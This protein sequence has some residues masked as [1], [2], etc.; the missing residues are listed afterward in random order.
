MSRQDRTVPALTRGATAVAVAFLVSGV[1]H[2]RRPQV[3][4]GA[5]PHG[6]PAPRALVILSGVAELACAAGLAWPASRRPAGLA[7]AGLLLA[8]FP[9]NV[10][11]LADARRAAR[12]RPTA[13]RRVREAVLW[14]RLPLQVTLVRWAWSA[15][16]R[17]Q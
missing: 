7:S 15:T 9:A 8:V 12:R 13:T 5:V 4:L 2:L 16:R 1:V 11:M 14:A 3:F 6:L 10:Q 17:S